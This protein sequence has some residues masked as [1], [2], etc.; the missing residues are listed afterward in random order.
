MLLKTMYSYGISGYLVNPSP[1]HS[2][3]EPHKCPFNITLILFDFFI[4]THPPTHPT[5]CLPTHVCVHAHTCT[6]APTHVHT[7]KQTSRNCVYTYD[8]TKSP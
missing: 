6:R 1:S 2:N 7:N 3:T 5:I 8:G 4:K